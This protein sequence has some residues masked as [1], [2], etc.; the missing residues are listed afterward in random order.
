[1]WGLK[2]NMMKH[3]SNTSSVSISPFFFTF[4]HRCT[5]HYVISV[6]AET[7]AGPLWLPLQQADSGCGSLLCSRSRWCGQAGTSV[8]KDDRHSRGGCLSSCV[9]DL[10]VIKR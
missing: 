4:S 1:M 8:Q 10:R 6:Q 7:T 3:S 2:K 5:I 9:L